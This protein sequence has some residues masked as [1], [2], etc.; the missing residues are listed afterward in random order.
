[1]ASSVASPLRVSTCSEPVASETS[2]DGTTSAATSE[3][4]PHLALVLPFLLLVELLTL[5]SI[6]FL[7]QPYS[8]PRSVL[9][10]YIVVNGALLALWRGV[11]EARAVVHDGQV[12]SSAL[13][14]LCVP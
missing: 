7:G 9:I 3:L 14:V 4:S 12:G 13:D 5:A 2:P 8:F 6:Y 10:L 11:V 1:M